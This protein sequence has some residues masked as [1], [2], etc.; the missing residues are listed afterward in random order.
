MEQDTGKTLNDH[1][2]L[3]R[4]GNGL[5]EVVTDP[6]FTCV[7]Q[8]KEFCFAVVTVLSDAGI[9]PGRLEEGHVRFDVNISSEEGRAEIK[10]LNSY[11]FLEVSAK[12]LTRD[13]DGK[14]L[15]FDQKTQKV[16]DMRGKK[17]YFYFARARHSVHPYC[18]GI[19][20][21]N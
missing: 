13:H 6:V 10:N 5:I 3:R 2:D 1:V 16:F 7:Q 11:N 15:G 19:S 4:A 9:T 8:A 14:T 21:Q 17:S 12:Q 20:G 18:T